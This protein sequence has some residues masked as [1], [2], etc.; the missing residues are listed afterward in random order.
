MLDAGVVHSVLTVFSC[1]LFLYV[2]VVAAL[3]NQGLKP[4]K[5]VYRFPRK[6]LQSGHVLSILNLGKKMHR[7]S[8][9]RFLRQDESSLS[10][11]AWSSL[12]VVSLLLLCLVSL[13]CRLSRCSGQCPCLWPRGASY[14]RVFADAIDLPK[15][16]W[17]PSKC[18]GSDLYRKDLNV[19]ESP[20]P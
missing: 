13:V 11:L 7:N 5:H 9:G 19:P 15:L 8:Q 17:Q 12:V 10:A 14:Q 16:R 1:F 4:L 20:Q 3:P 2:S 6:L 18:D